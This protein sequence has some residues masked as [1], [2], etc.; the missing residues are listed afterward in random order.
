MYLIHRNSF[1]ANNILFLLIFKCLHNECC[2][3]VI[4][5][6]SGKIRL[7]LSIVIH[8]L[9]LTSSPGNEVDEADATV[10][11]DLTFDP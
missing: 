10:S 3:I 4:N 11:I 5:E 1:S 2:D 7:D 9:I 8:A 6:F